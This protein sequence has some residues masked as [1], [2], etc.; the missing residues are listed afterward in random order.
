MAARTER[1]GA[2]GQRLSE[3]G[4]GAEALREEFCCPDYEEDAY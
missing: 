4:H 2:S 1:T 3:E